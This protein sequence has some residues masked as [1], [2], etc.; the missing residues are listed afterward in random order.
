MTP[1]ITEDAINVA[2]RLFLLSILP[3]GVEVVQGQAN[4]VPEPGSLD[5]IIFTPSSR[6]Q[7]STTTHQYNAANMA[8]STTS[9]SYP[10][11]SSLPTSDIAIVGRSNSIDYQ[12]DVYGPNATDN[13]QVIA[14]LFRDSYACDFLDPYQMQPLYCDDGQ[15]M[16]LVNGEYQYEDRWMLK[17]TLQANPGIVTP[18]QFAPNVVVTPVEL[19]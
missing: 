11:G 9:G 18:I 5:H 19:A 1:T 12:L 6:R 17:V 4:R 15:Q 3:V 16:P 13:A 2:L 10:L 8:P 14:T 7:L